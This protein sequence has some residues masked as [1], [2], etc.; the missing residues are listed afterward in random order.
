MLFKILNTGLTSL[1]VG[2]LLSQTLGLAGCASSSARR[3]TSAPVAISANTGPMTEVTDL[4][5]DEPA[6]S[7]E[8]EVSAAP[9]ERR[10]DSRS[11]QSF[12][13]W[14]VAEARFIRGFLPQKK[15]KPHLGIDLAAPKGTPILAAHD[16][17]VI[18]TGREFRGY[19]K[20]VMIEGREGFATLYAHFSKITIH[21]GER[22]HQGDQIGLMGRSGHATGTHL[23]FEVR[24]DRG[25]VDPL[26][27]LPNGANVAQMAHERKKATR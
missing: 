7:A 13:D 12:F 4:E 26:N 21:E 16:G 10:A 14:P 25:P 23:H 9:V 6:P 24:T 1:L 3:P 8:E 11:T 5:E 27:Y 15:R 17:T 20:M 18:Y 19:G 22:V 2:L